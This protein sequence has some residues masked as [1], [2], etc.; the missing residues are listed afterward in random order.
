MIDQYFDLIG[1]FLAAYG[2]AAVF[3]LGV[4]EEILFFLPTPFFFVGVGF[5]MIDGHLKF[6]PALTESFF[7]IALPGA[8]GVVLG[9][10]VIY[11]LFYWGGPA[12]LRKMNKYFG[13]GWQ[14]V[15]NLNH[16]FKKGHLDEVALILL[17]AIPIFPIGIVSLF[18]GLIR[19]EVKEF[20][21]TT[22][23]GTLI[24]LSGLSLLG[25]YLGREYLKYAAQVAALER[26]LVLFLIVVAVFFLIYFYVRQERSDNK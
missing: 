20:I 11:W 15:E 16:R 5:F 10:V 18:C 17:R 22:L 9:G 24:R 19:L 23:V 12:L 14:E 6:W 2:L 1:G 13:F 25:W 26:Y 3:L 8:I 4:S 21:W 7:R